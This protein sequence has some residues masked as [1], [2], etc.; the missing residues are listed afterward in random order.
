[1]DER[2]TSIE[3][4][5]L[6][7]ERAKMAIA[8]FQRRNI[9]GQYVPGRKEALA[10]VLDL[11]PDGALVVRGDSVSVD[12]VGVMPALKERGKNKIIDPFERDEAGFLVPEVQKHRPEMQRAAFSADVFIAGSNAITLDGKIV[13]TDGMGNRVSA[14]IFGPKKVIL[15][16]GANKIVKNVEEGLERIRQVAAPM[17]NKRH[18]LKHHH[19]QFGD[20]PCVRTGKCSDC[21]NDF[22]I[23]R[24]TVIIEGSFAWVKGRINVVIVGEELGI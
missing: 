22:R 6:Y 12:Q 11:I 18:F 17:N 10:A 20:L 15:V 4:K 19:E 21:T 5:W 9:N 3:Q 23:C 8:N 7:E 13:N 2:D 16:V 1:M 14:M 24:N